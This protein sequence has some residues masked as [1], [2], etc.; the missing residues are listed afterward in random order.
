MFHGI[1]KTRFGWIVDLLRRSRERDVKV[2]KIVTADDLS[3]VLTPHKDYCA[4]MRFE[5]WDET[6][7]REEAR[8]RRMESESVDLLRRFCAG[9]VGRIICK[10]STGKDSMAVQRLAGKAG[11]KFDVLFNVTTLDVAESNRMARRNGFEFVLPDKKYGGFYQFVRKRIVPKRF[12]RACCDI[13]KERATDDYLDKNASIV[14]LMGMRND[15]SNTRTGYG[16][17]WDHWPDRDWIALLPIRKWT[18][19]DV[20]LYTLL[21]NIEINDKYRYGYTRVG[22]GIACPF[23]TK[24]TWALDKFWYPKLYQRWR[25]ILRELFVKNNEWLVSNCTINE[26]VNQSWN[27][28]VCRAEATEEVIREFAKYNQLDT[29]TARRYFNRYCAGGC[30][31]S[32]KKPLKIKSKEVLAMNMKMFGRDINKFKCKRCLMREFGWTDQDWEN[33]VEMFKSQGCDLF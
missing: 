10:N 6:V 26:Y 31:N 15:E 9:N 11:L 32:R 8:I 19:L 7:K 22:C 30:L 18:E 16:D 17:V 29:E 21:E 20:W 2:R 3:V 24:T 27:G 28:G 14:F 4:D 5:T 1:V 12:T 13:F 25:D 33:Q 23:Y